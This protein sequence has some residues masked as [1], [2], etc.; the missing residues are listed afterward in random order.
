MQI[1]DKFMITFMCSRGMF[2]VKASFFPPDVWG[3][4]LIYLYHANRNSGSVHTRE[5]LMDARAWCTNK[6]LLKL[7]VGGGEVTN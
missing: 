7:S 6:D 3:H 1:S 5:S 4:L 2:I